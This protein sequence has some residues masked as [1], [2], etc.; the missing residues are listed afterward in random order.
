MRQ[1]IGAIIGFTLVLGALGFPIYLGTKQQSNLRRFHAVREGVLYRSAQLSV[2][3]IQKAVHD[4]GIR[5][6]VNL[7]D[8]ATIQDQEEER[9]C[10]M[11][12]IRFVRINPLKWEGGQGKAPVD[13]GLKKFLEVM[14]DPQNHPVLL[15]CF[16]GVHRTG[17]YVAVYRMEMENWPIDQA[18]R[19]MISLGYEQYEEHLDMKGYMEGFRKSGKYHLGIPVMHQVKVEPR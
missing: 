3:G 1:K 2:P 6:M 18:V 8:G 10:Q 11:K 16:R 19:E 9:Y 13:A 7:R 15:H 5:T 17:G 4:F 14:Q 12:G